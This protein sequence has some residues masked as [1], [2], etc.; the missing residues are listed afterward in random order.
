MKFSSVCPIGLSSVLGTVSA[1]GDC[2]FLGMAV[3]S[4]LG[5]MEV[6]EPRRQAM[7]LGVQAEVADEPF[8]VARET[9]DE[10]SRAL[11]DPLLLVAPAGEPGP[12]PHDADLPHP[13]HEEAD[14]PRKR[15]S[16]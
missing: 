1:F 7:D 15:P 4:T 2:P 10:A 9:A 13:V 6:D 8:E 16:G 14:E 12:A 11:A 3:P 5:F